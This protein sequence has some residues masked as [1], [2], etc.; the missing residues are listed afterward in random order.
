MLELLNNYANSMGI[1]SRRSRGLFYLFERFHLNYAFSFSEE[2]DE[3]Y[4]EIELRLKNLNVCTI[5][6]VI[7]D[8]EIEKR[9]KHRATYTNECITEKTIIDYKK[10]QELFIK[11]ANNSNLPIKILNTDSMDWDRYAKI[12]LEQCNYN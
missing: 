6:C 1:H 7:S 9:L 10:N 12:I 11:V 2:I 4:K 8:S 3:M 5:L